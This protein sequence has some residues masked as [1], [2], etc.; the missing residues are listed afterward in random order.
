MFQLSKNSQEQ[1][2]RLFLLIS[3]SIFAGLK[4]LQVV[5][6]RYLLAKQSIQ[7]KDK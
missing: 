7:F 5:F 3:L 4:Y 2:M 1:A 6:E